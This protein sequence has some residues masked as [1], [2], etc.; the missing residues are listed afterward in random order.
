MPAAAR[1]GRSSEP[2]GSPT[3][4]ATDA[5]RAV[6]ATVERSGNDAHRA[7]RPARS[8][9]P[10]AAA[11]PEEASMGLDEEQRRALKALQESQ[12]ETSF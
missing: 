7:E 3:S 8:T 9:T 1:A 10:R 6:R 11:K 12:L 5:K 4:G 2:T